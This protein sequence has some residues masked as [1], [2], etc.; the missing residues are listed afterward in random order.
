MF[1]LY[2]SSRVLSIANSSLLMSM[3]NC[4]FAQLFPKHQ[5]SL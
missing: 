3:S 5:L 2:I 4:E 1:H